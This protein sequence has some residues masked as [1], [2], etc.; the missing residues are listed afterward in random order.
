[1]WKRSGVWRTVS[2]RVAADT[3]AAEVKAKS[4]IAVRR[5]QRSS[6]SL[7][8]AGPVSRSVQGGYT[9]PSSLETAPGWC[10]RASC[11]RLWTGHVARERAGCS[12]PLKGPVTPGWPAERGPR[13]HQCRG[14]GSGCVVIP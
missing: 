7:G 4:D 2:T 6:R 13:M 10:I 14:S 12:G 5:I 8:A 1:V 9:R 11:P 3:G